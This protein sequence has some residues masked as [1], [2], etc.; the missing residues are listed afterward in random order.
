[1]VRVS[2]F[3]FMDETREYFGLLIGQ[4]VPV[5]VV[6]VTSH[7]MVSYRKTGKNTMSVNSQLVSSR[8]TSSQ[9]P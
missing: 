4:N 2:E 5:V 1:M 8:F 6:V 7:V 3:F 9:L